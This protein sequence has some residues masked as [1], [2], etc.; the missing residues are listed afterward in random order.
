MSRYLPAVDLSWHRQRED[1]RRST[2]LHFTRSGVPAHALVPMLFL[3]AAD[4]LWDFSHRA[5]NWLAEFLTSIPPPMSSDPWDVVARTWFLVGLIA[6][7]FSNRMHDV[8]IKATVVRR[9]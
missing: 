5:V 1:I 4:T 9:P 6:L 7:T 8:V 3:A 2:Y